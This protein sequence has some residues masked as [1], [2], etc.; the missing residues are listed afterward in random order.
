MH[1]KRCSNLA[2][3]GLVVA[4]VMAAGCARK[5]SN[6]DGP[7]DGSVFDSAGLAGSWV[8]GCT[9]LDGHSYHRVLQFTGVPFEV[10]FSR[11]LTEGCR[12][13]DEYLLYT[14]AYDAAALID[15]SDIASWKTIRGSVN[16]VSVTLFTAEEVGIFNAHSYYDINDWVLGVPRD[17]SGRVMDKTAAKPQT[18]PAKGKSIYYTATVEGGKLLLG[19]YNDQGLALRDENSEYS[20]TRM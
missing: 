7:A 9:N 20:Y 6:G 2:P 16:Q 13:G 15:P 18:L 11:F 10:R 17:V 19:H 3:M 5:P 12:Q 4:V 8:N 14:Y 1:M